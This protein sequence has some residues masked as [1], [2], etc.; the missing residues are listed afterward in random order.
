MAIVLAVLAGCAVPQWKPEGRPKVAVAAIAN[1]TA[2][3]MQLGITIF[4]NSAGYLDMGFDINHEIDQV[5]RDQLVRSGRYDLVEIPFDA[6]DFAGAKSTWNQGWSVN[7]LPKPL[8]DKLV[9]AA[10]G[11]DVD[12][13]IAVIDVRDSLS[14][15]VDGWGIYQHRG[16][17][18]D[19]YL[20]YFVFVVNAH[21][22]ITEASDSWGA[23]RR[24]DD[25]D[26]GESWSTIPD[27]KRAEIL[28]DLKSIV[29]ED[30]P[31]TLTVLGVV[32]GNPEPSD[33]GVKTCRPGG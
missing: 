27:A 11:H 25:I 14:G 32:P 7:K 24:V 9:Q 2:D 3:Q 29:H 19:P 17:C 12:Y 6:K 15:G 10:K 8:A 26:W 33:Y 28:A 21:T 18:Y 31:W 4:G 16:G 13:I 20:S 30:I 23:F 5:V 1:P 22:G